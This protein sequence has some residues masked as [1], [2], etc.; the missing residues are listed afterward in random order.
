MAN[1]DQCLRNPA[2][3]SDY[4]GIGKDETLGSLDVYVS[5]P[6]NATVGIVLITDVFGEY[7]SRVHPLPSVKSHT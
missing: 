3:P 4:V 7:H 1:H 5:G 6:E 2:P